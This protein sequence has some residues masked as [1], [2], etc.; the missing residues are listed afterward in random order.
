MCGR[1]VELICRFR[2]GNIVFF[3]NKSE[4]EILSKDAVW[5]RPGIIKL[6]SWTYPPP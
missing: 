4:L 1:F 6:L 3:F 5:F 2:G